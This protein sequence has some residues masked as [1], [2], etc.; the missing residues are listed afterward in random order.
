MPTKQNLIIEYHGAHPFAVVCRKTDQ[1]GS[2]IY[3]WDLEYCKRHEVLYA[4][5]SGCG[6]DGRTHVL[7]PFSNPGIHAAIWA[8]PSVTLCKSVKKR[9]KWV[10][11]PLKESELA[12][13]GYRRIQRPRLLKNAWG[14]RSR[15]PLSIA[16]EGD[17]VYCSECNDWLPDDELSACGHLQWC[18]ECSEFIV[19]ADMLSAGEPRSKCGHLETQ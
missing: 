2:R 10:N 1:H 6:G 16:D 18:D 12:Q 11:V 15:N 8:H 17:T 9:G 19:L 5:L 14:D 4:H 7:H 3:H 13:L